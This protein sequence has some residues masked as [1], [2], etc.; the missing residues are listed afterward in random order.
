M[1]VAVL[2][3]SWP[4]VSAGASERLAPD[5]LIALSQQYLQDRATR[6]TSSYTPVD[7]T[8][9]STLT[10]VAT[11]DTFSQRI[12]AETPE[13]DRLRSKIAGTAAEFSHARVT[14]ENAE[15]TVAGSAAEVRL[16]ETTELFPARAP[17]AQ[18]SP[19]SH[20]LRHT[21]HFDR[22]A[23]TWRLSADVLDLPQNAL[24]PV[25]YVRAEKNG[26]PIPPAPPSEPRVPDSLTPS[27]PDGPRKPRATNTATRA[28]QWYDRRAAVGYAVKWAYGRHPDYRNYGNDCTNFLSQIFRAGGWGNVL[29][30]D[31]TPDA[32]WHYKIARGQVPMN[33]NTWSVAHDLMYFGWHYSKRLRSYANEPARWGDA[34]FVDWDDANG[35][36]GTDKHIDHAMYVTEVWDPWDWAGIR[37]TYHTNDQLNIPMS[38]VSDKAAERQNKGVRGIYYFMDPGD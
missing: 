26:P 3:A 23:G 22:S 37:V 2:M 11:T 15:T 36:P 31:N 19:T 6:V 29:E 4:V 5:A 9:P 21:L 35:N 16:T 33:S 20:R 18:N 8:N 24:D 1:T 12:A 27:T 17:A 38:V 32:W 34:I 7:E 25:P 10:R 14:V 28:P 30:G 13:L